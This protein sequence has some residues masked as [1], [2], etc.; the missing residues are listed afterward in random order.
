VSRGKLLFPTTFINESNYQ[1]VVLRNTSNSPSTYQVELGWDN[2]ATGFKKHSSD[3]VE[4]FTIKPLLGEIP[5]DS[6]V[7]VCIRF[8][9]T[10]YKKYS[11]M[12]KLII[13]GEKCGQLLLEGIGAS[14][15]VVPCNT[16]ENDKKQIE[17]LGIG[18]DGFF[19]GKFTLIVVSHL[20][21]FSLS[22]YPNR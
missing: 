11:Q 19:N 14:P 17:A 9:P 16:S 10:A 6:F 7:L 2:N 20:L 5:A 18:R 15:Y 13:N 22:S 12:I 21:T 1:T 8:L 4:A 3:M